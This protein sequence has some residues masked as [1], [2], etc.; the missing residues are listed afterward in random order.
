[1]GSA[2]FGFII[3]VWTVIFFLISV[4][5][6]E[7]LAV[8]HILYLYG[9]ISIPLS[10]YP[11]LTITELD[12]SNDP[13][14]RK[15][16]PIQSVA[17]SYVDYM[18]KLHIS[19]V[20]KGRV[21]SISSIKYDVIYVPNNNKKLEGDNP[22]PSNMNANEF[23]VQTAILNDESPAIEPKEAILDAETKSSCDSQGIARPMDENPPG[24]LF[25]GSINSSIMSQSS[26][27]QTYHEND[28]GSDASTE[29]DD[30]K[31]RTEVRDL[32]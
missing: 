31:E 7:S 24:H 19:R 18:N 22:N 20:E 29:D 6:L 14:S 26:I 28:R 4:P 27:L 13:N 15:A 30:E 23:G 8:Y 3:G 10:L 2:L 16:I 21:P 1:M 17:T 11:V 9:A 12:N 32:S 25:H 5:L